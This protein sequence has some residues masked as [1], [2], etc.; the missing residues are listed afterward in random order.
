MNKNKLKQ[1]NI[2]NGWQLV[3]F[4]DVFN[5][6][7]ERNIELNKN[8]LTISAQLGLINQEEFFNKK[9]AIGNLSNYF[10][11]RKGDFAY[12]RSY[13]SGYPVGAIKRLNLYEKGIVSSLYFCFSPINKVESD[14]L[15]YYFDSGVFNKE[16]KKIAQEGA[17]NHGLLNM[18]IN[19]F[20]DTKLIIPPANEQ[21]RIVN[22]LD[23]WSDHVEKIKKLIRIKK[24]IRNGLIQQV[25]TGKI[26][27]SQFTSKWK[28]QY[29]NDLLVEHGKKSNG[30][31]EVYSVSVNKGLVNQIEHLGRSFSAE[32]TLHYNLVQPGDVVYTKSPTGKFPFGIIKQSKIDKN[33]IVS[34][35]YGVFTPKH[36]NMGLLLDAYFSSP[37]NA[38]NYLTP[39]IQKG[40]KN[41]IA[42]TNKTFLS[43]G[44]FLPTDKKEIDLIADAFSVAD[45]E[46]NELE[47]KL[48][49]IVKQ[50]KFLLNN[51]ITGAI[52]TPEK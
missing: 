37:I 29:F 35:L 1:N 39:L 5:R 10:L 41:T 27:S 45:A 18:S 12:N 46:I 44:L 31:E 48:D 26:R 20:F 25:L 14:Y 28:Y 3:S 22:T 52:R 23:V 24:N 16:I 47:K 36:K 7:T 30:D 51:L 49:F 8:T 13:S 21:L 34:P 11:L 6:L 50:K 4:R 40:A 9:I 43:S 42:I 33:V 32:T 2:P 15:E 17:R 19:D 38:L